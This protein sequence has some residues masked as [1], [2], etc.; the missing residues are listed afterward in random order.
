[1]ST[2][3]TTH[4]I[5][6]ELQQVGYSR[7][8]ANTLHLSPPMQQAWQQLQAE[9]PQMPPDEF[10]PDGGSYRF[11]R[12]D[13]FYFHPTS[14]E[15]LCLPHRD[16]FQDKTINEVTGGVVRQFAPL[17]DSI[18]RNPFLHELIRFDFAQFPMADDLRRDV[19]QVDVHLIRVLARQHA[20]G[21]PTPEG[22]H[23][24]GAM[25]VTVHLAE[26]QNV[27]GGEVSIY[28]DGKN[29]LKSFTLQ[30]VMDA[31]FFHDAVLWHGV[32]P[33]API[34]EGEGVRSIL[35]FDYHHKPN[36]QRPE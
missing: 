18:I 13:S 11:R 35:T 7:F 10:L 30:N 9:Y 28:D 22:I 21:E 16:Y 25:F 32:K 27:Q 34:D 15:L 29:H 14:G 20:K 36:L 24:D 12:Y 17:T 31:Y 6:H 5:Q 19:W 2:I 8:D 26:L 3:T 23:R 4:P 1:M 33:I